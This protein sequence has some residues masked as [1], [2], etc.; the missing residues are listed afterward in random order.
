MTRETSSRP[1]IWKKRWFSLLSNTDVSLA[2]GQQPAEFV[3]AS[4]WAGSSAIRRPSSLRRRAGGDERQ[5]VP[6]GR[7]H[8]HRVVTQHEQGAVQEVARVLTGNR[9]LRLRDHLAQR[10][11]VDSPPRRSV[12]RI[13]HR[14]KV[15]LRQRLHPRLEAVRRH[16]D[17]SDLLFFDADV[18]F[19]KLL[20]DSRRTSSPAASAHR[21]SRRTRRSVRADP[22]RDPS[23]SASGR[24][25][26]LRAAR[27]PEWEWCSCARQSPETAGAP[28]GGRSFGRQVPWWFCPFVMC[29]GGGY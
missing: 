14:G 13:G 29:P 24:R 7:D 17:G 11:A 4:S 8:A 19:R 21:A 3:H 27:S 20:H 18:R 1:S 10:L 16:L 5:A 25:R 2:L 28:S 15:V 12:D 23:P 9:K 26:W 22:P 6:V